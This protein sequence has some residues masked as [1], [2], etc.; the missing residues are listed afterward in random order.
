MKYRLVLILMVSLTGCRDDLG[1]PAAREIAL[2]E[3]HARHCVEDAQL[4]GER[5]GDSW[6]FGWQCKPDASGDVQT[7]WV[8]VTKGG[9]VT[10]NVEHVGPFDPATPS[11]VLNIP[12]GG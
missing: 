12:H 10:T 2:K 9:E 5:Q 11:T 7:I 1:E 4:T 8:N 6:Q 3:A